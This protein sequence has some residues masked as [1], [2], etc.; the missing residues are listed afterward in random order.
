MAL[1]QSNKL[2]FKYVEEVTA[3]VTPATSLKLLRN[4]G[5]TLNFNIATVQSTE[6]TTTGDITDLVPSSGTS[7]GGVNIEYSFAEYRPFVESALRGVFSTA[8]NLTAATISASSVDNSYNDSALG[9]STA[10][11][12]PGHW[13]A[14][15]GFANAA[16]NGL[17][18]VVSVTTGKIIV[19]HK[20][21]VTAT[22]SPTITIKGRSV[23]NGTTQ[24]TFSIE[25][26]FTDLATTFAFYKGQ[27][28]TQLDLNAASGAIVT[29]SLTFMGGNS[30]NGTTTIGTGADTAATTNPIMNAVTNLG[31][32][33]IDG[34][35]MSGVYFKSIGLKTNNQGRNLDAIGALFP[36][37]IN[38]GTLDAKFSVNAYFSDVAFLTKLRNSTA[39]SLS[40][41]FQDSSGNYVVIDAPRCKVDAGTVDG[42]SA[43]QDIMQTLSFSATRSTT[44]PYSLQFSEL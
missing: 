44:L 40:F 9:F 19:S 20:T 29:G 5:S 27:M 30:G 8:V 11:I 41:S 12:L 28:V 7:G 35:A 1:S 33:F 22:A 32:V 34:V 43:N 38:S 6:I 14:V 31:T 42:K 39:F 18:K 16:N 4:T 36:I 13:I 15:S 10:N 23:R 2:K 37:A 3:G 17:A 24:K 26:E 21:L 25:E